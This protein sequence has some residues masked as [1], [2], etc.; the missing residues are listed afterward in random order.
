MNRL[1]I[2]SLVLLALPSQAAEGFDPVKD[3]AIALKGGVLSVVIPKGAH[4][5]IRTFKVV[6]ASQ[7]RLKLGPLPPASGVDDAGD[8]IWHGTVRVVLR[9]KDLDQPASLIVTYQPCTEGPESVCFLPQKRTLS[10]AATEIPS[11]EP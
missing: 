1:W 10:V 7:G 2:A 6:L 3:M 11:S 8:P 9:G 5:K 4:L